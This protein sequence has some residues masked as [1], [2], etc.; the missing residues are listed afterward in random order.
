[1]FND[2]FFIHVSIQHL[3]EVI[4]K[5]YIYILKSKDEAFQRFVDWKTMV[6]IQTRIKVKKLRIDNG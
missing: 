6:E 1:M 4:S 3:V 5:V 2:G